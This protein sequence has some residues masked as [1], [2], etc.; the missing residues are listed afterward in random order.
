M[1]R[2]C[3][4]SGAVA[5]G[6][7]RAGGARLLIRGGVGRFNGHPDVGPKA[8]TRQLARSDRGTARRPARIEHVAARGAR[9]AGPGDRSDAERRAPLSVGADAG[10][11]RA[12]LIAFSGFGNP[13]TSLLGTPGYAARVIGRRRTLR[14]E[15]ELARRHSSARGRD[16]RGIASYRRRRRRAQRRAAHGH[17]LHSDDTPRVDGGAR[18]ERHARGSVVTGPRSAFVLP[19]WG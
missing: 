14:R 8:A 12:A 2:A 7:R 11:H 9:H 3:A 6:D 17:I 18:R 13:P 10:R 15:L 16:L 19:F 4:R 5:R 1:P